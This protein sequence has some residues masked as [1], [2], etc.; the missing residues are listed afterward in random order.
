MNFQYVAVLGCFIGFRAFHYIV[1]M[2]N[3]VLFVKVI[4][5][6]GRLFS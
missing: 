2:N 5:F 6:I 3:Y 4:P 1:S